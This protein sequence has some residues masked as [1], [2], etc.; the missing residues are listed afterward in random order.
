M[1]H[2]SHATNRRR[3]SVR[4]TLI[5]AA[6]AALLTLA[7]VAAVAASNQFADVDA[8]ATHEDGISFMAETGVTSG[9]ATGLFCPTDNVTREQMATFMHRLSGQADG[10]DPS[11]DAAT[12]QGMTVQEIQDGVEP[13]EDGNDEDDAAPQ[14]FWAVVDGDDADLLRGSGV[15]ASSGGGGTEGRY[16]VTFDEPVDECS[17]Q[18]TST[19]SPDKGAYIAA[20]DEHGT[21][22]NSVRVTVVDTDGV[23]VNADVHLNVTC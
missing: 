3:N 19:A 18:A 23:W 17:W 2:V 13:P 14:D 1:S 22:D 10:V 8:G 12:L 6:A 11:V 20:V 7:A 16:T 15:D 9:C 21:D 4:V 5:A